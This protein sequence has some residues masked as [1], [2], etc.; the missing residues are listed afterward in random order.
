MRATEDGLQKVVLQP[1]G[2][3]GLSIAY[4]CAE[5]GGGATF[6]AAMAAADAA[7]YAHKQAHRTRAAR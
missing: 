1:A 6:D 2:V 7:M 3:Q 4:G 5:F